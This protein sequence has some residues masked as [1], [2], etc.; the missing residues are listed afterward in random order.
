MLRASTRPTESAKAPRRPVIRAM[1]APLPL[2]HSACWEVEK[3]LTQK[4]NMATI[5]PSYTPLKRRSVQVFFFFFSLSF[6]VLFP[7][8]SSACRRRVPHAPGQEGAKFLVVTN[9]WI[10]GW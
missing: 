6:W 1:I 9:S 10:R 2:Y 4:Q 8:I 5:S 7:H 3:W